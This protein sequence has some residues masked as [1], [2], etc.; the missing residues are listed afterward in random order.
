MSTINIEDLP[1]EA[2]E[3]VRKQAEAE[4]PSEAAARQSRYEQAKEAA[5]KGAGKSVKA[6]EAVVKKKSKGRKPKKSRV[7]KARLAGRDVQVTA[8]QS[9]SEIHGGRRSPPDFDLGFGSF[10]ESKSKKK[11]R[12][13]LL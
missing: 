4:Q 12:F 9:T 11:G 10:G 6:A 2:Q 1:A 13:D 7:K 3:K 8:M 5:K